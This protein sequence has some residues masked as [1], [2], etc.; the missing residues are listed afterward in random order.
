MRIRCESKSGMRVDIYSDVVCPW[1]Y[2]GERRFLRV[3]ESFEGAEA[4]EVVFRAYQLDPSAPKEAVPLREYL[5][6]RF[7]DVS[8]AMQA[9]V[10]EA[11]ASEGIEI[12]WDDALAANTKDAHRLSSLAW[13]EDGAEVQRALVEKLF[14]M[15]FTLGGNVADIEALSELAASVGMDRVR[16]QRYLASDEGTEEVDADIEAARRLGIQG[17]PTF[18]FDEQFAVQGAQPGT[19]FLR[20]LKQVEAQKSAAARTTS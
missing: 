1:C 3:L 13:R 4:V 10:S 12:E 11:A 18:V 16:V 6:G 19:V 5:R 2:I 9:R 8:G 20:A 7:G 14:E 17:V 15:H